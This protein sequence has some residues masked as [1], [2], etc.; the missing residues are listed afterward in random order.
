MRLITYEDGASPRPGVLVG[1]CVVPAT[2][3]HAPAD[4]VRGPSEPIQ[5]HGAVHLTPGGRLAPA[6]P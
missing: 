4:S 3:L 1:A 6:T 2:S 5:K